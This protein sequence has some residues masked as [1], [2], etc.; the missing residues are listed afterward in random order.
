V[1]K[2]AFAVQE[3]NI[4]DFKQLDNLKQ[5]KLREL[6]LA[7]NPISAELDEAT[8]RRF[9]VVSRTFFAFGSQTVSDVVA[10]PTGV[11]LQ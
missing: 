5:I 8:Y 10:A 7:G 1:P 2:L 4:S 9:A 6:V 3:N 11:F